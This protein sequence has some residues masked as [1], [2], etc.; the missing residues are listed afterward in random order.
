M[1]YKTHSTDGP[2]KKKPAPFLLPIDPELD[3]E[4]QESE[5]PFDREDWTKED[6]FGLTEDEY[7]YVIMEDDLV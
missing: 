4:E 7:L 3:Q 1:R 2:K 5:K 6:T